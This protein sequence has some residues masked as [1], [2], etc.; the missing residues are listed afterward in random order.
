LSRTFDTRVLAENEEHLQ[1]W[2]GQ[3]LL[4]T[5]AFCKTQFAASLAEHRFMAELIRSVASVT[6]YAHVYDE[7]DYYHTLDI[8]DAARAI[9]QNGLLINSLGSQLRATLGDG[10]TAVQGGETKIKPIR[11]QTEAADRIIP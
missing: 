2:P 9:H 1:R 3:R 7:G 5:C 11:K 8:E 6:D 4:W 10:V